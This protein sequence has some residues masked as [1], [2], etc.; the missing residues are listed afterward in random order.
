MPDRPD[1][2]QLTAQLRDNPFF[3]G[4]DAHTLTDLAREAVWREHAAG[5]VVFLEGEA[6]PGLYYLQSGWLKA[7]KSSPEGREQVLR[8][9]GPGETFNEIGAFASH[10]NPATAIALEAAGVWLL[11]R[12]AL[13][14]LLRHQPD[15]AQR[16]IE[17]IA[18]RVIDLV[19]LVAD[20]SLRPVTGRLARMLLE[21][22]NGD[23]LHRPR[24]HTQAELAARLGTV[25]DVVQ[26][27]LRGLEGEGAIEVHKH[28]I[29]IRDRAALEK[30]AA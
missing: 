12:E 8:F 16:V 7:V 2:A 21:E 15:L 26:R 22:A 29:H 3:K 10:P 6:S 24:W 17:N 28:E 1:L 30:L 14:R 19:N 4:L 13:M 11:R 18:G 20:L 25:P 9:I 23:V 5:E 27:A